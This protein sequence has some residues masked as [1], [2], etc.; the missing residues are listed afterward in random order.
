VE[1]LIRLSW[2]PQVYE[3]M[4]ELDLDHNNNHRRAPHWHQCVPWRICQLDDLQQPKSPMAVMQE[5]NHCYN[6]QIMFKLQSLKGSRLLCENI[7]YFH[8]LKFVLAL[9]IIDEQKET[10]EV[11]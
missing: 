7:F 9:L 10:L 8:F 3:P 6:S 5:S 11:E 1:L 4:E 2:N